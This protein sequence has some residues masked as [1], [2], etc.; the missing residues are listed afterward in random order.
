MTSFSF[1][2]CTDKLSFASSF[3]TQFENLNDVIP[4]NEHEQIMPSY[5][6]SVKYTTVYDLG[7]TLE[8][9][10]YPYGLL[11]PQLWTVCEENS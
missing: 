6:L 2:N 9:P 1:S 8:Y 7:I 5:L 3:Y 4:C 10:T 11:K